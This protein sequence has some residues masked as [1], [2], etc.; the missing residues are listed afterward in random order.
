MKTLGQ[1][2]SIQNTDQPYWLVSMAFPSNDEHIAFTV[3]VPRGNFPVEKLDQEALKR[4]AELIQALLD[5]H[6]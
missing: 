4:A 2:I 6:R 3:Q 5:A 1:P